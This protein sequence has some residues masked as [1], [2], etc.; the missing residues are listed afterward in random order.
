[1][2]VDTHPPASIASLMAS[3]ASVSRTVPQKRKEP[4]AET[5][6][7]PSP[8]P[9]A[10]SQSETDA[11]TQSTSPADEY[12]SGRIICET[13]GDGI[14]IRDEATG[15]FTVKHWDAHRVTCQT[16]SQNP[17][18]FAPDT[19]GAQPD[20]S[21]PLAK[22]RRAKRTEEERIDYLRCD[23]YVAKFE[24]YRVL[25]ASCDKWIRLRPNSTYCSIPWDAHRKSCLAKRHTKSARP[26][27]DRNAMFTSDPNIKRFDSERVLCRICEKW[28]SI[29]SENN[30]AAV[31]MW[32]QHRSACQPASAPPPGSSTSKFNIANVP[33]P[34]KHL[35]ALASS[36]SLPPPPP[37]SAHVPTVSNPA[38]PSPSV[39]S[40]SAGT[41]SASFKEFTPNVLPQESRRRNADQRAAAL[42]A[43]PLLGE[44]EPARVFCKL[45]QKWVQL[46]QDSTFCSYPWLQH[47]AKCLQRRQKIAEREAAIAEL[48]ATRDAA[49][50]GQLVV[51]D[52]SATPEPEEGAEGGEDADRAHHRAERRRAKAMAKAEA[53]TARLRQLEGAHGR[54]ASTPSSEDDDAMWDYID[55]D[56][57]AP[58][59]LADLDSPAGRLEFVARSIRHLYRVTYERADELTIAT[60]VTY[61]NATMPP[62]KHEDFDTAEVTK[63]A[64]ALQERGS[65]VFE[66][67]V[68]RIIS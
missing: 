11:G 57:A 44:V 30:A 52:S 27:D 15:A 1:M 21:Q 50:E 64:M 32:M 56:V 4:P 39:R 49:L 25:C 28:V 23:P 59:K 36:S 24:A 58:P 43:D 12:G 68:I 9:R 35:L 42:R 41:F 18:E 38:Q 48:R 19:P 7:R 60:L 66:G 34:P 26:V 6:S 31:K 37:A 22:R 17:P 51:S 8:P 53:A 14:S 67:D 62:D 3:A 40:S 13:C 20:A 47:R 63:A 5:P 2:Q 10:D 46:R 54:S 55:V 45:C 29:V 65:F 33:P 61:L 16:G